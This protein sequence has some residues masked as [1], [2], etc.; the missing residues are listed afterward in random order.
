MRRLHHLLLRESKKPSCQ[1]IS[2]CIPW[3]DEG[4]PGFTGL[5]EVE[6]PSTSLTWSSR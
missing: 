5:G 4:E 6:E 1:E 2:R 3:K